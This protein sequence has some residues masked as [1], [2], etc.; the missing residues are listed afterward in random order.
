MF[1]LNFGKW[2]QKERNRRKIISFLCS[3]ANQ[4]YT[5][6]FTPSSPCVPLF[7]PLVDCVF[8]LE[9]CASGIYLKTLETMGV[10]PLGC[11]ECFLVR[12]CFSCSR[13]FFQLIRLEGPGVAM[14]TVTFN[15]K[16]T[17]TFRKYAHNMIHGRNIDS[18]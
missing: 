8:L 5:E 1:T 14:W 11:L 9:G 17:T 3:A 18:V 4:L 6:M 12:K 2:I 16:N 15:C 7:L 10:L 13:W